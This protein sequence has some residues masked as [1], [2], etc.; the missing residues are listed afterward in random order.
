VIHEQ[1]HDATEARVGFFRSLCEISSSSNWSRLRD[2]ADYIELAVVTLSRASVV[3][4]RLKISRWSLVV[5]LPLNTAASLRSS[6]ERLC[7]SGGI[8]SAGKLRVDFTHGQIQVSPS[9]SL[10]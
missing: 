5:G 3:R 7:R 9:A 6:F 1:A 4:R 10:H 2:A 8:F